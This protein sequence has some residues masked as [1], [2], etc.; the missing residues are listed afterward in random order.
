MSMQASLL[1]V[2]SCSLGEEVCRQ[3]QVAVQV[4]VCTKTTLLH[5]NA[6]TSFPVGHQGVLVTTTHHCGHQVGIALLKHS[7]T[8]A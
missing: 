6:C 2:N 4:W 1:V 5:H 3:Q 8:A 7:S